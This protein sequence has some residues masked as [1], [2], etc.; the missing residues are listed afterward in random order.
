M[1]LPRGR[2]PSWLRAL[3]SAPRVIMNR[4][5]FSQG[6]EAAMWRREYPCV[7]ARLRSVNTWLKSS[8]SMALAASMRWI[9]SRHD[10]EKKER[11]D[12]MHGTELRGEMRMMK[13]REEDPEDSHITNKTW[14]F[15]LEI[16]RQDFDDLNIVKRVKETRQ[17]CRAL[18]TVY[19]CA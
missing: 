9:S 10:T 3:T 19:L 15:Q 4:H 14:S 5:S 7:S 13:N 18:K 1:T 17:A 6:I 16:Q 11:R 8:G 2:A 12:N